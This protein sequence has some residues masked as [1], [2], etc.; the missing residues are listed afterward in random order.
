M[1]EPSIRQLLTTTGGPV[2]PLVDDRVYL[3][4]A[5]QDE[6]RARIVLT[7]LSKSPDHTFEGPNGCT[8]GSIQVACLAPTY[9]AA[10]EL[11]DAARSMLDGHEGEGV[12][13][14]ISIDYI[15]I[16]DESDIVAMTPPGQP[17]Q[18]FGVALEASFMFQINQ[19]VN[20]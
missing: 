1:I 4:G 12:S 18:T 9:Q 7:V 3:G 16:D 11:A 2:A 19:T 6:R 15:E 5:P 17:Q 13:P 8:T 10:H 14:E 20:T